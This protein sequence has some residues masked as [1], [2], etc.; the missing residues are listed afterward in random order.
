[1][2]TVEAQFVLTQALA[3]TSANSLDPNFNSTDA[4]MLDS[5]NDIK[6]E[7]LVACALH[8]IIEEQAVEIILGDRPLTAMAKRRYTQADL[9]TECSL[10]SDRLERLISEIEEL[11]GNSGAIVGAVVEMLQQM[12]QDRDTYSL[13]S[14]CKNMI[15]TPTTIDLLLL[16][17]KPVAILEPLCIVLDNWPWDDDQGE[18]EPVYKEFGY[19]L[20]LVITIYFRHNLS[21]RDLGNIASTSFVPTFIRQCHKDFTPDE[22]M[23]SGGDRQAK[24]VGWIKALYEG[25]GITDEVMQSSKPQEYYSL[26]PTL[27]AQTVEACDR[28]ILDTDTLRGGLEC[29]SPESWRLR[30]SC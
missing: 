27:I 11:D 16:Y 9:V 13:Y 24:L 23:R 30:N 4:M 25:D 17:A 7:F 20:L 21:F 2:S 6:Q 3:K 19:T 14:M 28:G 10:N 12:C 26:V 1:M 18:Y 29:K 8:R 5:P 15:T 22:L